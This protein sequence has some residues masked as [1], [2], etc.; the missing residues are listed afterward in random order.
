[1]YLTPLVGRLGS[2]SLGCLLY[3]SRNCQV[4]GSTVPDLCTVLPVVFL[5]LVIV[6][7]VG[8]L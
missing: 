6:L 8:L 1:M 7:F 4:I 5:A 2:S 3:C